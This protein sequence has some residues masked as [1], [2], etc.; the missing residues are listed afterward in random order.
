MYFLS[1]LAM[2]KNESWIINE[3]I[4]HYLLEVF[5][6]FYLIDNGSTDN[7]EE[8]IKEYKSYYTLVKDSTRLPKGTQSYLFKLHFLNK[9]KNETKWIIVCDID[10]YI[11]ARNKYNTIPQALKSLP[12]HIEKIW[13][14]WKIYGSSGHIKHPDSIIKS[15]I[16]RYDIYKNDEGHGK[17]ISKTQ[18]MLNFGCCGHNIQL[19]TNNNS[20][21]SNGILM[22]NFI[23]NET[24]CNSLNLHLNHYMLLSEEYYEKIKC[25]RGGGESGITDKYT[26]QFFRNQDRFYN[27]VI[28]K[29]LYMKYNIFTELNNN[30]IFKKNDKDLFHKY[31]DK[32]SNYL[33]FG[34]GISTYIVSL[35]QNINKIISIESD[36][37][38]F[39]KINNMI[40]NKNKLVYFYIDLCCEKNNWGFP[41]DKC[42]Y[43]NKLRY[44]NC[45]NDID[46]KILS[47]IDIILI[48]GRFR[49]SCCLKCFDII[50]ENCY[51][52]FNNFLERKKYHIILNYFDI[53]EQS[54]DNCMVVLQKKTNKTSPT[55]DLIQKYEVIPD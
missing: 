42:L 32:S 11:Y 2:F 31:I 35:K 1:V 9:I 5:D 54:I 7:Y 41:G 15:F 29:E 14:P 25:I 22:D 36:K 27:N 43:E 51:L 26:L 12:E 40:V 17:C 48:D 3:W 46:K 18:N 39:D 20:Y 23:M 16:K 19:S 33:E 30:L 8:K 50:N 55:I 44:V 28:D 6:H 24:T 38:W 52:L 47:N 21:N 45:I 34:S 13:L 49:V 10:E 53:I 4:K 37:E